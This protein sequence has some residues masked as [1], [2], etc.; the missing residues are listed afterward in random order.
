M[1]HGLDLGPLTRA[2]LQQLL[3]D[4]QAELNT[5]EHDE[6]IAL[7]EKLRNLV[8]DAG[9]DPH[10]LRFAPKQSSRR[11]KEKPDGGAR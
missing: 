1:H 10:D 4:A 11:K 2:Q 5:R 6:R 7:E 8:E 9:F 3:R